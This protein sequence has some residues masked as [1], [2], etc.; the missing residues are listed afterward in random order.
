MDDDGDGQTGRVGG[1]DS[2]N[3]GSGSGSSMEPRPVDEKKAPTNRR[4]FIPWEDDHL[5]LVRNGTTLDDYLGFVD[6]TYGPSPRTPLVP[7]RRLLRPPPPLRPT[8]LPPPRIPPI[9]LLRNAPHH[10]YHN[11]K[12]RPRR[13][14][15]P[16]PPPSLHQMERTVLLPAT[17][18]TPCY[19]RRVPQETRAWGLR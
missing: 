7:K 5:P 16:L 4:R 6:K 8:P 10:T 15:R 13:S 17:K 18:T 9:P 12:S 1:D 3:D 19:R 14:A 11:P 2:G